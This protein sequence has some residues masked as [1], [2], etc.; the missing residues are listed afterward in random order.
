M[1]EQINELKIPG[2]FKIKLKSTVDNRGKFKKIFNNEYFK[3][4]SLNT[5]WQEDFFSISNKNVLRG[6]HFQIPPYHQYK[7][8]SCLKG[9]LI[10]VILDLRENSKSY[11]QFLFYEL[12]SNDNEL[13]YLSPGI[14][15]G[16][17]SLI[18]ETITYYKVSSMYSN[19]ND[20]GIFWNSFGYNW[21]ISN[22]IIS[23]RDNNLIHLK[24]Y[25]SDFKW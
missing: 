21:P 14:A 2:C 9:I 25:E 6:M 18:D 4:Y 16:F 5:I 17:L 10:D 7:L 11:K 15:H 23:S 3:K 8:I 12:N 1:I 22:P 20:K 24:D 13:I 19:K